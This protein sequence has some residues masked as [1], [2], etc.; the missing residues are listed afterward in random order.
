MWCCLSDCRCSGHIDEIL[1][2]WSVY[3]GTLS[4]WKRSY[5]SIHLTYQCRCCS[6]VF[7]AGFVLDKN[8]KHEGRCHSGS[9][10]PSQSNMR[11]HNEGSDRNRG[12]FNADW[13]T[14]TEMPI[15]TNQIVYYGMNAVHQGYQQTAKSSVDSLLRHYLKIFQLMR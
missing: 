3:Q 4:E 15:I 14:E 11:T 10:S 9:Q 1:F 7:K 2:V 8:Q 13:S 5:C 12:H 6:V